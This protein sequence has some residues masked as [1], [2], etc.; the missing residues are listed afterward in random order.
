MYMHGLCRKFNPLDCV[1]G[2]KNNR[3]EKDSTFTLLSTPFVFPVIFIEWRWSS[4][5][6]VFAVQVIDHCLLL[7]SSC[8]H[9][10]AN[11]LYNRMLINAVFLSSCLFW[12]ASRFGN[13][14]RDIR[15]L[16]TTMIM[17]MTRMIVR[18]LH[19]I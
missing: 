16:I 2:E 10:W 8:P 3:E 14:S 18:E 11:K 5:T 12:F 13:M 17:T 9:E 7:L 19:N 6:Y 4:N 1:P 15:K